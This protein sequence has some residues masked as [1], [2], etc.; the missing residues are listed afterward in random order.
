M[1]DQHIETEAYALM[2]RFV[3]IV[4]DV[5]YTG[6]TVLDV[7]MRRFVGI[8]QEVSSQGIAALVYRSPLSTIPF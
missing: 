2:R 7:L 3:G 5:I 8:V 4:Q 6:E 1:G